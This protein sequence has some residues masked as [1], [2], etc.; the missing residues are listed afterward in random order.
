[1]EK[2]DA[3]GGDSDAGGDHVLRQGHGST[4][5]IDRQGDAEKGQSKQ[6]P[7]RDHH[8]HEPRI[9]QAGGAKMDSALDEVQRTAKQMRPWR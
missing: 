7:R 2:K 5:L 1:V 3:V 9:N 6:Q 4:R 8:D